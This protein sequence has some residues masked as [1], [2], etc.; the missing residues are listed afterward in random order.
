MFGV[1]VAMVDV[2]TPAVPILIRP[3]FPYPGKAAI[4]LHLTPHNIVVFLKLI[5]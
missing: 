5:I 2:F 1:L 4:R 3:I